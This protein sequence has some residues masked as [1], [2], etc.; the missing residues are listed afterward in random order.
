MRCDLHVSNGQGGRDYPTQEGG[1]LFLLFQ[2]EP[3]VFNRKKSVV[4]IFCENYIMVF[5]KFGDS[6]SLSNSFTNTMACFSRVPS[7]RSG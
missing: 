5:L 2:R 1:E 3:Y 6:L 4:I 7:C